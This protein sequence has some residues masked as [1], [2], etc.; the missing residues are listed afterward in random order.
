M[1]KL[2]VVLFGLLLLPSCTPAGVTTDN[3]IILTGGLSDCTYHVVS[4]GY[5]SDIRV[6]RCPNSSVTTKWQYGKVSKNAVIVEGEKQC[7]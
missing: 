7:Q 5:G 4:K 6:I 3:S 2:I 1:K